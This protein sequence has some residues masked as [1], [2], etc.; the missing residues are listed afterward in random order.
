MRASVVTAAFLVLA[1]AGSA[2][3]AASPPDRGRAVAV[4]TRFRMMVGIPAATAEARS[5]QLS[6]DNL[7]LSGG[8]RI[9]VPPMGFYVATLVSS[10]LVRS[11]H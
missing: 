2:Q 9:E 3:Q 10:N 7:S 8:R 4:T 11:F 6:L 5:M 1:T